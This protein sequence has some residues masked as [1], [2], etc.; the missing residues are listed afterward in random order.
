MLLLIRRPA[1][2]TTTTTTTTN[3]PVPLRYR[4][5]SAHVLAADEGAL[6]VVE[7]VAS[8]FS[9]DLELAKLAARTSRALQ[10]DG[11]RGGAE[12]KGF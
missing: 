4:H 2:A 11:W 9:T 12:L 6:Q 1:A 5:E 8:N 10:P 7:R 3:S